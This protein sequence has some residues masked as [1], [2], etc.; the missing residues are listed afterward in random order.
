M[1]RETQMQN[2]N[3]VRNPITDENSLNFRRIH[4]AAH[5]KRLRQN[6]E[7]RKE[8]RDTEG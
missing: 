4:T 3:C 7:K 2:G 1:D 5:A 8:R 6:K